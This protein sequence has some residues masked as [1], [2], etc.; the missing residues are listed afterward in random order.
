[1]L[2]MTDQ[3]GARL[4]QLLGDSTGESVIRIVKR[5]RRLRLRRDQA[6]PQDATF[7]HDGRIVLVLDERVSRSLSS[8]TLDIRQT[9]L[10][11]RLKLNRSETARGRD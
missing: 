6:R 3:A 9:D 8:R 11:P 7:A 1:M 4:I 5:K 10:G 2:T